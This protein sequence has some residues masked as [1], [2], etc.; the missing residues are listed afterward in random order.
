MKI[1]IRLDDITPDMDWEKFEKFRS[2]MDRYYVKPL[3]GVVPQSFDPKLHRGLPREDFWDVVEN[4]RQDGWTIAM[5]GCHHL[6]TTTKGGLLPL[7]RQ[8][9]FAGLPYQEQ[10]RL[11]SEGKQILENHGIV[12]DLFMAPAHSYDRNTLRALLELGFTRMTDGFGRQPY[13]YRG[14][15]FYPIS[16]SRKRALKQKDGTTTFVVHCNTLTDQDFSF[17]ENVFAQS[18]MLPYREY[19][20]YTPVRRNAATRCREYW[21]AAAKRFLVSAGAAK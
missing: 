19:L 2:L 3:I 6:Y 9:E 15:T 12:T 21:L 16:F 18:D 11:L 20:Y 4:L 5:H 14:M 1:A 10:K 7:N 17:Y 13:I 8:S